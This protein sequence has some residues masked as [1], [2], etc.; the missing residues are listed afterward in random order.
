VQTQLQTIKQESEQKIGVKRERAL[1]SDAGMARPSKAGRGIGREIV[2]LLDS[3]D[4]TGPFGASASRARPSQA[5][6]VEVLD[7]QD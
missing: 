4:E 1:S 3:D 6:K 2:H 5:G 7:L